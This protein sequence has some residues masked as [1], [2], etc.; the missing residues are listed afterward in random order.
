M[1]ATWSPGMLYHDDTGKSAD[2]FML[3]SGS[4]G[5]DF[6]STSQSDLSDEDMANAVEGKEEDA[7]MATT[8]GEAPDF[9]AQF[10]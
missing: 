9:D 7:E 5:S 2:H 4:D 8:S 1:S 3:D 6:V 10:A